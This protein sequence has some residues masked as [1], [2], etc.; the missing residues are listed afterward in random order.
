MYKRKNDFGQ[1]YLSLLLLGKD[2]VLL[3]DHFDNN[4]TSV[5]L[6]TIS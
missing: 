6:T 3:I 1:K 5:H 4:Y 2:N